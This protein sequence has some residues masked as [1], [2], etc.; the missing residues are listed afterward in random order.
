MRSLAAAALA[1]VA[2]VAAGCG[3]GG[4]AE[5]GGDQ[6]TG[7][8]IFKTKCAGC[9]TMRAAGS[10]GTVG[11]NLDYAFAG[12]RAQGFKESSILNLVSVWVRYPEL[13]MPGP[14]VLFKDSKN[15]KGDIDA[16]AAYVAQ[17]AGNPDA[18]APPSGGGGTSGK[19]I[20][21]ANCSSCHT[22]T[23]AG[24]KGT[25]GPNLDQLKPAQARVQ[26]Q[27]EHGGSVMPAFKGV[28]KPNQIQIVAKYVADNAGK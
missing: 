26:H 5:A 11:P 4:L 1:L 6:S 7:E 16:V 27:V 18:K 13:P 12:D 17:N 9:H 28:L 8:T 21:T 23:A 10:K 20:F 24:A 22:L 25:V 2:L 3:T 14:N 19:A 15:R